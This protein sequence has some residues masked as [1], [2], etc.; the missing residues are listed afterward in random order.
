MFIQNRKQLI[1]NILLLCLFAIGSLLAQEEYMRRLNRIP[2]ID[3]AGALTNIYSGGINN[4][5][6]QFVDIDGDEDLFIGSLNNPLGTIHFLEN[7]GTAANPIFEYLDSSYFNIT[8]DL[9]VIPTLGD[10]DGD[11]DFDL[12]VGLFDGKI[13][14]YKNDG[15]PESANFVLQ[16]KLMDNTGTVIDIGTTS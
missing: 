5:E 14:Y 15:T 8:G 13:D 12:L 9:S 1:P 3:G 2:V 7:V 10:L 16:G 11:N 4:F 6:Y